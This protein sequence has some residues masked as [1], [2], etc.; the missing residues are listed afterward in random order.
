MI[1]KLIAYKPSLYIK[2]RWNCFDG[3]LVILSIIDIVVLLA[4]PVSGPVSSLKMLKVFRLVRHACFSF[5]LMF[6]MIVITTPIVDFLH[7][8]LKK[9]FLISQYC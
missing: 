1:I 7:Q 4:N 2:N 3:T 8:K 9:C 6:Q 5:F